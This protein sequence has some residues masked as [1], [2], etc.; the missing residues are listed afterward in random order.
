MC[1]RLNYRSFDRCVRSLGL[2]DVGR[3]LSHDEVNVLHGNVARAVSERF[4]V[5]VR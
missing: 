3:S 2:A 1:F 5:E 4:G